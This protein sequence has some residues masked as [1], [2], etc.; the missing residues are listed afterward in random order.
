MSV[1]CDQ[2]PTLSLGAGFNYI[3]GCVVS[4]EA[5]LGPHGLA[6][7]QLQNFACVSG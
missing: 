4:A 1:P 6:F 3:L 2:E 5:F 7:Q